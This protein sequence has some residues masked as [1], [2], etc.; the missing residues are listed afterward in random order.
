MQI[1][2]QVQYISD[3]GVR[4]NCRDK[5]STLSLNA[6]SIVIIEDT[7]RSI[8]GQKSWG[9][10]HFSYPSHLEVYF[11]NICSIA[12]ACRRTPGK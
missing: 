8:S 1:A 3:E 10:Q 6:L 2:D 5:A 4:H 11:G 9:A 12:R 7:V